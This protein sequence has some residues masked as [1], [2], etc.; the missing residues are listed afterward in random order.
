M[1]SSTKKETPDAQLLAGG[2]DGAVWLGAVKYWAT[3][4]SSSVL[5]L[6]LAAS[7]TACNASEAGST[8]E[9]ARRVGVEE[10]AVTPVVE[11]VVSGAVMG[12]SMS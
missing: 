11:P 3:S 2:E 4:E 7:S 12:I 10:A 8:E 9:V 5:E 1:A 6:S